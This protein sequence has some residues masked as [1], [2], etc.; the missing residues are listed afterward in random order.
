MAF[1]EA[2]NSSSNDSRPGR[3]SMIDLDL[4]VAGPV[5]FPN[6]EHFTE[7]FDSALNKLTF[8]IFPDNR[9]MFRLHHP[10]VLGSQERSH[11]ELWAEV[12]V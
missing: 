8:K 12:W 3:L 11:N 4:V 6:N 10:L 1:T 5:T 2:V 9:F 7:R